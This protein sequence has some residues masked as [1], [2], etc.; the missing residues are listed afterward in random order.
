MWKPICNES[1]YCDSASERLTTQAC[2][3]KYPGCG[4]D[5]H[6]S[7]LSQRE[8]LDQFHWRWH[9]K[10]SR[11]S[12][13][14]NYEFLMMGHCRRKLEERRRHLKLVLPARSIAP[15]CLWCRNRRLSIGICRTDRTTRTMHSSRVLYPSINPVPRSL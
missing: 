9:D 14:H 3:L 1:D 5:Y 15:L 6:E 2:G 7:S 13:L 11:T 8:L 10:T 4:E 12:S